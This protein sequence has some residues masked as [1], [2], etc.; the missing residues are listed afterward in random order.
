MCFLITGL[1]STDTESWWMA[2]V[3]RQCFPIQRNSCCELCTWWETFLFMK[4]NISFR[5]EKYL[6]SWK[7][8]RDSAVKWLFLIVPDTF[9]LYW[10][11]L[12]AAVVS[13]CWN[14]RHKLIP[15]AEMTDTW[16][17]RT[18]WPIMCHA[19]CLPLYSLILR[20]GNKK[21]CVG[22]LS[23]TPCFSERCI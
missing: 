18:R 15:Y 1:T 23:N 5:E 3:F 10:P 2:N 17:Y 14:V 9:F 16:S 12:Q 21:R 20:G 22:S 11:N 13:V 4:I 6:F 19:S 8:I 7:E